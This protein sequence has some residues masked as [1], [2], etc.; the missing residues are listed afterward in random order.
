MPRSV[1][2]SG[3]PACHAD[4]LHRLSDHSNQFLELQFMSFGT[5][6]NDDVEPAIRGNACYRFSQTSA[7]PVAGHRAPA[8]DF[9]HESD[10]GGPAVPGRGTRNNDPVASG[11]SAGVQDLAELPA[12]RKGPIDGH[13]SGTRSPYADNLLL[14]L[15]RRAL[16]IA[17]PAR[18]RIR[19]RK[20]CLRLRRRVLG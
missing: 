4:L 13:R 9:R 16:R 2:G 18:V 6:S 14:P 7:S 5:C 12:V 19:A 11:A 15:A 1:G 20:P 17:R 10:A 3:S 8:I